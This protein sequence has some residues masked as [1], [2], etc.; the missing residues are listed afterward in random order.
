MPVSP[1]NLTIDSLFNGLTP[2]Q[3]RTLLN[4]LLV[5]QGGGGFSSTTTGTDAASHAQQMAL[6]D[7]FSLG[8]VKHKDP[9]RGWTEVGTDQGPQTSSGTLVADNP[10]L[11]QRAI[12]ALQNPDL[13]FGSFDVPDGT[14]DEELGNGWLNLEE[15]A[16]APED[17]PADGPADAPVSME[18]V[19]ASVAGEN[20]LP[21]LSPGFETGSD[22]TISSAMGVELLEVMTKLSILANQE[23]RAQQQFEFD[24]QNQLAQLAA[25]PFTAIQGLNLGFGL[26]A[27]GLPSGFLGELNRGGFPGLSG[28]QASSN[29]AFRAQNNA[30]TNFQAGGQNFEAP[31]LLSGQQFAQLSSRLPEALDFLTAANKAGGNKAF[32]AEQR[33]SLIP[34]G[35]FPTAAF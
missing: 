14:E 11:L 9:N 12:D 23:R 21:D 2:H 31:R 7:L 5:V 4:A 29:P 22:G 20:S 32:G 13:P 17:G 26:G 10:D 27:Q 28:A 19:A 6:G 3:Q 24:A 16:E 8:G 34:T 18:A 15:L 33:N 1:T 30:R 35:V 25:D